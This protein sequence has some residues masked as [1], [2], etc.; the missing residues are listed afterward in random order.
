MA[1]ADTRA[2]ASRSI[3]R[4]R[5]GD[6]CRPRHYPLRMRRAA[7]AF[8][9]PVAA[10]T[11]LCAGLLLP[12]PLGPGDAPRRG[13]GGDG[14]APS[15]GRA[16]RDGAA[17]ARRRSAALP[18][19]RAH[20]APGRRPHRSTPA[21]GARGLRRRRRRSRCS[22]GRCSARSRASSRQ[23]ASR[24]ARSRSTTASSRGCTRC[25]WRSRSLALWCLVRALDE[26]GRW[27]V[28]AAVLLALNVYVH[29]YGVVVGIAAGAATLVATARRHERRQAGAHRCSPAPACRRHAATG[30][31]LPRARLAPRR[32]AHARRAS[33]CA[34][35]R[36]S[37]PCTR[38]S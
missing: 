27:W 33:P 15:A 19:R 16:A 21:V 5:S 28:G 7:L 31:G 17:R 37:T 2:H 32:G 10:A 4:A 1:G 8:W 23:P 36:R 18:A 3:P 20:R 11:A 6:R 35:R 9:L 12:V 24:P 38:P 30:R 14:R 26:G 13:A 34:R 25:S 22:A 29:P